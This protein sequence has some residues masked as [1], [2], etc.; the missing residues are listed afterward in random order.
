VGGR[1]VV[2]GVAVIVALAGCSEPKPVPGPASA[3]ASAPAGSQTRSG[4]ATAQR[5]TVFNVAAGAGPHDVAPA[6]DGGVWFTA[7]SAGY[8]GHLD[9]ASGTVTQ[10]PLGGGSRPHGVIVGPD[11]AAWITDGGLNAIVRVDGASR[12]VRRFPLPADRPNANLNTAAFDGGGVLWFTGQA[13]V[14]GRLDPRSGEMRVFDAPGGRGPYGMT[15]TPS[16]DVYYASLAGH[17]IARIDVGTGAVTQLQPPTARQGARRVW[18]DS[19]GRVWVSEYDAGQLGQYDP[20]TGNWREWKLPGAK[21]QAYAVY[22]DAQDIVWLS[23]TGA[24]TVVRFDPATETFSAVEVPGG[25][26]TVRQIL[27]RAGEVWF[28]S[29]GRDFLFVVRTTA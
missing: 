26:G 2:G 6:R 10:V 12:E 14:Y 4:G 9:V 29:S 24:G 21:P 18:S 16:G 5:V 8:L 13:G 27:G 19:R 28:P 17:H 15:T 1:R 11:G 7:Q 3:P 23:D 25:A 20:A 22:V